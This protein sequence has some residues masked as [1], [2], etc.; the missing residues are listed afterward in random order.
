MYLDSFP[1]ATPIFIGGCVGGILRVFCV[2]R[3]GIFLVDMCR[4]NKELYGR[5][6]NTVIKLFFTVI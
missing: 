2:T 5:N 4:F 6:G 3:Q 1:T